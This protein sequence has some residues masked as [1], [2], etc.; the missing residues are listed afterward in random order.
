MYILIFEDGTF[1]KTST[2]SEDD[3][4]MVNAGLLDIIDIS[5]PQ[6]PKFY[7][8]NTWINVGLQKRIAEE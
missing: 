4:E 1:A 8:Y 3:K 7:F 5:V 2:I 6:D